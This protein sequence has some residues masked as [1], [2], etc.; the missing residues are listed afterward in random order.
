ME[1]DGK[2]LTEYGVLV[3]SALLCMTAVPPVTSHLSL[4]EADSFLFVLF[5][6]NKTKQK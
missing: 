6:G 1:Q 3:S 2:K 4:Q 5:Q